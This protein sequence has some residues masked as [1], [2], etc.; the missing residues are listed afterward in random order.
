MTFAATPGGRAALLVA[1]VADASP[2]N[3][4]TGVRRRTGADRPARRAGVRRAVGVRP[5]GRGRPVPRPRSPAGSRCPRWR[6]PRSGTSGSLDEHLH[7]RGVPS[8]TRCAPFVAPF[9]ASTTRRPRARWLE[10]LVKALRRRR[11]GGRLLPG[12]RRVARSGHPRPGASRCWPTPGT[13][14]S[15]S[16]R[17][18][19]PARATREVPRPAGAVGPPAARRGA[20]PRPS[21]SWPSATT[22]AELIVTGSG[23]LAGIA[24]LLPAAAVQPRQADG[25]P[26]AELTGGGF[27]AGRTGG[28]AGPS[29]ST[30]LGSDGVRRVT[31]RSRWRSRSAS[32]RAPASSW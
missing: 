17:C 28:A 9:D 20:S 24:A 13:P 3:E 10:S 29:G 12:D 2:T 27:A 14:R 19:R 5:D 16:A 30:S 23:D 1:H 11:A 32:R 15:P 8:R 26:R 31:R 7:G 25:E 4:P 22:L 18:A 6:P 21:T